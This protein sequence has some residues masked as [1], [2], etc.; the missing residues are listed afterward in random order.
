[1][2]LLL[3]PVFAAALAR[4]T[5]ES[6]PA[7]AVAGGALILLAVVVSEVLPP[8]LGAGRAPRREVG[9]RGPA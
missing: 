9:T 6:L 3:E 1:V 5:G 4:A 2:I 8:L 7:S